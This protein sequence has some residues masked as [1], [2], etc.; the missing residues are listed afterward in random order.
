MKPTGWWADVTGRTTICGIEGCQKE[1]HWLVGRSE[2]EV[3]VVCWQCRDEMIALFGYRL[4]EE[5]VR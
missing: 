2:T 4:I 1:A 3:V 5:A